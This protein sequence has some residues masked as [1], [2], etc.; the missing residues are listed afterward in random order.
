M[1]IVIEGIDG[2]GKT[3]QCRLLAEYL[4][5]RNIPCR[6]LAE[7]S[8][9]QTGMKIRQI[10]AGDSAPSAEQQL[11]MF[12][13][14]RKADTEENILPSLKNGQTVVM[15]RYWFSSCAY[16]GAAGLDPE[17]VLAENRRRGFPEPD[18]TYL[19]N[20]SPE[21]AMERISER[22]SSR[23]V[24]EKKEFLEKAGNIF[25][26][27]MKGDPSCTVISGEQDIEKIHADIAADLEKYI[28]RQGL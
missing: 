28:N 11:E 4:R 21:T 8:E 1:F 17:A 9:T 20:I 18:R 14:D 7:P 27:L 26:R 3:T 10:L 2:S 6:E 23:D 16:Q 5:S 22:N 19:I 24:F 25:M 12:L 13:E 15:D